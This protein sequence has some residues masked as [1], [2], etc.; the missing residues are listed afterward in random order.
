MKI[1]VDNFEPSRL[2]LA[3]DRAGLTQSALAEAVG[4]S[5][6]MIRE[7]ETGRQRPTRSTLA[8]IARALRQDEL[9]FEQLP[10][11]QI[12][13]E[14][15]S[16]RS[17]ARASAK[18]RSRA[19]AAGTYGVSL[20][21]PYL[22]ERFDLPE[23]NVPDL[24][25]VGPTGAAEALRQLWGL[26]QRPISHMVGLLESRGVRVFSLSEDCDAIDAFS[27]W[28]DGTPFV[29]LNTRKTAERSIW[30]AAHELGHLVL[31]RHGSPQGQEAES[32]ADKFAGG[33][34]LPEA[35]FRADAPN[36]RVA[37]PREVLAAVVTMKRK[38]RASTAAIGRR[39]HDLE[40]M[41]DHTY[42]MFNKHL[43]VQ[44][45]RKEPAPL[46]RETS[47]VLRKALAALAEEGVDLKKIARELHLPLFELR[48]LTFGPKALDGEGIA[49][50]T[51]KR[52]TLRLVD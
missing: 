8:N 21:Y 30:D 12:A 33:F 7:Y 37:P 31:H 28:R 20:L 27:L 51:T 23:V 16:F 47:V 4:V 9:F 19:V 36:V 26:G 42:T 6:R 43:A 22:I 17:L 39:L 40:L 10:V 25:D 18:L 29:F 11:E 41:T 52:P 44:W 46:P 5:R 2:A 1:G 50:A 35:A 24:R 13:L 38:W 34:L 45:R 3:R 32:E 15:A 49:V 48:A 14:A